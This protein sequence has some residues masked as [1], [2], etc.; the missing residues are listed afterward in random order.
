MKA[1]PKLWAAS[2]ENLFFLHKAYNRL[3]P[4]LRDQEPFG[5]FVNNQE[6]TLSKGCWIRGKITDSQAA[7]DTWDVSISMQQVSCV[8]GNVI[9]YYSWH[10]RVQLVDGLP[11]IVSIGLYPTGAGNY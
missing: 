7:S 2:F 11:E 9:A 6:Y 1:L 4:G 8:D 10:F 3:S 5:D